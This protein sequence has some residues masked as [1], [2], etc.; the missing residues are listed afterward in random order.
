MHAFI[1][2]LASLITISPAQAAKP[3]FSCVTADS[4]DDG[5]GDCEVNQKFSTAGLECLQTLEAAIQARSKVANAQMNASNIANTVT[6]GNA[7]N[8][9]FQGG[10]ANYDISQQALA[11]LIN[12]AK[13]ARATVSGQMDHLYYPEDFDAPQEVIGDPMEFLTNTSCYGENE[14]ILKDA[15][16]RIDQ[17]IAD[18]QK[19]KVASAQR[20]NINIQNDNKG[21]GS[22]GSGPI[23]KSGNAQGSGVSGQDPKEIQSGVSGM[24]KQ[25]KREQQ[26]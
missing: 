13:V 16:K 5:Q 23:L 19:A 18:L 12:A 1:F 11:E 17:H 7:Q 10:G 2:L 6:K 25:K 8:H 14:K 15:V 9:T 26:K 22:I 4:I 24:E 21:Q 3:L 20:E